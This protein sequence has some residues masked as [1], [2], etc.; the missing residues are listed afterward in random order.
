MYLK[1][2]MVASI[3]QHV[4]VMHYLIFQ[5]VLVLLMRHCTHVQCKCTVLVE[6]VFNSFYSVSIA[7][8]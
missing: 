7:T 2:I 1:V 8:Y 4:S 5:F 3:S 6:S